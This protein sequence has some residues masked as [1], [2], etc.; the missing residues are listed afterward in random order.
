MDSRQLSAY[1]VIAAVSCAAGAWWAGPTSAH[2]QISAAIPAPPLRAGNT[3]NVPRV[4]QP[5]ISVSSYGTVTLRIEQQ[6]LEWVL[7]EIARQ[8]GWPDVRARAGIGPRAGAGEGRVAD[9]C[10]TND[11]SKPEEPFAGRAG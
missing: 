3:E 8:S 1:L 7:D 2:E 4:A 9:G 11:A 10:A 5:L 6:P